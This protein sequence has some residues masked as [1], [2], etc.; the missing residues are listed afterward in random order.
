MRIRGVRRGEGEVGRACVLVTLSYSGTQA[1]SDKYATD[2]L[3]S[4]VAGSR[5]S[6]EFRSG[7]DMRGMGYAPL[8][9]G[10]EV[11]GKLQ[12]VSSGG[13]ISTNRMRLEGCDKVACGRC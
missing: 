7:T 10:G 3:E 2:A 8:K 11:A 12:G 9:V 5:P 1:Q 6:G 13:D 4:R